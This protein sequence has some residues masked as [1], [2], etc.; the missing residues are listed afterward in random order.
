MKCVVWDRTGQWEWKQ[1][2][3]SAHSP[4]HSLLLFPTGTPDDGKSQGLF[5]FIQGQTLTFCNS[6][7]VASSEPPGDLHQPGVQINHLPLQKAIRKQIPGGFSFHVNSPHL[8]KKG[9]E[10]WSPVEN[11]T[12]INASPKRS[13]ASEVGAVCPCGWAT[14]HL[15]SPLGALSSQFCTIRTLSPPAVRKLGS[16]GQSSMCKSVLWSS[17]VQLPRTKSQECLLYPF[18]GGDS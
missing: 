6:G 13:A 5:P 11:M 18:L 9:T 10:P 7:K 12:G 2:S 3:P 17:R 4:E 1:E 14:L 15:P 16:W 8:A